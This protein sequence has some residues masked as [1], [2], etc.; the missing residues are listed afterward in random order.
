[1]AHIPIWQFCWSLTG[2]TRISNTPPPHPHPLHFQ[3]LGYLVPM[4]SPLLSYSY[5]NNFILFFLLNIIV[6]DLL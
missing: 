4:F 2:D 3:N 1:M 6:Y 5:G